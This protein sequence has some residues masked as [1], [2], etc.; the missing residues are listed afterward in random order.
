MNKNININ[1]VKSNL[2]FKNITISKKNEFYNLEDLHNFVKLNKN[3]LNFFNILREN[4]KRYIEEKKKLFEK[5]QYEINDRNLLLKDY[6]SCENKLNIYN[7]FIGVLLK[8]GYKFKALNIFFETLKYLKLRYKI[9]P[10]IYIKKALDNLKSFFFIKKY[11]VAGKLRY[12]PFIISQEASLKKAIKWLV[13]GVTIKK[14]TQQS[15]SK[16]LGD[17]IYRVSQY[18]GE[19]IKSK[20]QLYSLSNEHRNY[21]PYRYKKKLKLNLNKQK[22]NNFYIRK[23]KKQFILKF[24]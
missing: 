3:N 20:F 22:F 7:K 24:E 8:N 5:K 2:N 18:K 16:K 10:Y 21:W 15:F 23:K 6:T 19:S 4:L 13:K 17:E 14:N 12:I 11:Y 1:L 9:S